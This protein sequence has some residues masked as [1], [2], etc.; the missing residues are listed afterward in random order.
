MS[1]VELL[2]E[3]SLKAVGGK[4]AAHAAQADVLMHSDDEPQCD[5]EGHAIEG[6]EGS[7]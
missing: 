2:L 5:L 1:L 6:A 3:L 4:A 7:Q